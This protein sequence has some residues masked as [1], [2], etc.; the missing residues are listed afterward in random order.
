MSLGSSSELFGSIDDAFGKIRIEEFSEE[1]LQMSLMLLSIAG[2]LTAVLMIVAA[3]RTRKHLGLAITG[4]IFQI[5]GG[6]AQHKLVILTYTTDY[7]FFG[8]YYGATVEEAERKA[9]EATSQFLSGSV[10]PMIEMCLCS[11]VLFVAWLLTLIF[12]CKMLKRGHKAL[13]IPALLLYLL[14]A[15]PATALMTVNMLESGVTEQILMDGN[16]INAGGLLLSLVLVM[17]GVFIVRRPVEPVPAAAPAPAPTPAP[18]P[19]EVLTAKPSAFCPRCGKKN[20]G[21]NPFCTECGYKL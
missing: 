4:G 16:L 13:V 19:E 5:I 11:I 12:I 7:F 10:G 14:R 9:R 6:Y 17:I 15:L 8:T 2:V 18:T 20:E 1:Y 21:G 3:A